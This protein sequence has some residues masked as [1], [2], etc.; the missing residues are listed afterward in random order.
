MKIDKK[1]IKNNQ[2]ELHNLTCLLIKYSRNQ[3]GKWSIHVKNARYS[4]LS[5]F[6]MCIECV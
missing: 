5:G 6:S 4:G 2:F 1:N 3:F